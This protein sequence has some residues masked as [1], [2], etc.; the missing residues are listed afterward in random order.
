MPNDRK[1]LRGVVVTEDNRTERFFRYLLD[2][3]S[4]DKRRFRF[5]TAP[6][7]QGD[8]GAWVQAQYPSLVS[9]IRQKRQYLCL[10]AVRDGDSDGLLARKTE[11]DKAL[12]EAGLDSRSESERIATPVPTWSIETWLLALAGDATI[13]EDESYKQLFEQRFRGN[14]GQALRNAALAWRT[15]A[16]QVSSVP[17][18]GDGKSEMSRIEAG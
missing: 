6:S 3:L 10:V 16:D 12:R 4:F 13:N 5:K 14:E 7:G 2:S 18:L 8:A 17:S 1:K 9:L 15:W 11:L